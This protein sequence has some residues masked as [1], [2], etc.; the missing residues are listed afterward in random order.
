MFHTARKKPGR[1]STKGNLTDRMINEGLLAFRE[2]TKTSE[3]HTRKFSYLSCSYLETCL[4]LYVMTSSISLPLVIVH[5]R[6]L[7]EAMLSHDRPAHGSGFDNGVA[8]A[9]FADFLE[10]RFEQARI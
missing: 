8:I 6:Q 3:M 1:T 5:R 7:L 9:A 4:P 10:S 2:K